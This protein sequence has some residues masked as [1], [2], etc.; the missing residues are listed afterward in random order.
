MTETIGV[1]LFV[2]LV[3][4]VFGLKWYGLNWYESASDD[5]DDERP[6]D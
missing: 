2:L 4:L 5:E 1:L 3:T 6:E